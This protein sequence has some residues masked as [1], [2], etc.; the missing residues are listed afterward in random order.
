MSDDFIRC[1][2]CGNLNQGSAEVC[3]NCNT[4]LSGDPTAIPSTDSSREDIFEKSRAFE[5]SKE[6]PEKDEPAAA[7][8]KD[9]ESFDDA[10]DRTEKVSAGYKKETEVG[11]SIKKVQAAAAA[12]AEKE[13]PRVQIRSRA[14]WE[15][16]DADIAISLKKKQ[17]RRDLS[18]RALPLALLAALVIFGGHFFLIPYLMPQGTWE[19][20]IEDDRGD[21]MRFMV[22]MERSGVSLKGQF[23]LTDA[24]GRQLNEVTDGATPFL[25]NGVIDQF[26]LGVEG[27]FDRRDVRLTVYPISRPEVSSN[28][29]LTGSFLS[30]GRIEGRAVNYR[31]VHGNW[32]FI[33]KSMHL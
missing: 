8:S 3:S 24:N 4:P 13:K 7:L 2:H 22:K 26:P 11:A 10:L 18:V 30:P 15:K 1:R 21:V 25:L 17:L 29:V 16:S 27:S 23:W 20:S 5:E 14:A 19:G 6:E 32:I 9:L 31:N 33:R 12:S 28:L